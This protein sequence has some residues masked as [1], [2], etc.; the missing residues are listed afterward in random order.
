MNISA[1][2]RPIATVLSESCGGG[3]A[4]LGFRPDRIRTLVFMA[5]DS[6]NMVVIGKI[7]WPLW[8]LHFSSDL[9]HSILAGNDD[10]HKASTDF[11]VRSDRI[12]YFGVSC[13]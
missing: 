6:S 1:T 11:E 3:K 4:A 13:P 9:L 2:S 10:N 12:T 7:L 5:T 8:R